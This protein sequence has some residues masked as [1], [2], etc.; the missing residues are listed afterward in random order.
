MGQRGLC[1][2]VGAVFNL[3]T[4]A[5]AAVNHESTDCASLML[6]GTERFNFGR[7]IDTIGKTGTACMTRSKPGSFKGRDDVF[8][9]DPAI[10]NV[11]SLADILS[12]PA[13]VVTRPGVDVRHGQRPGAGD[14]AGFEA[15]FGGGEGR[16]EALGDGV[17]G[18]V[19][20]FF[21]GRVGGW[22]TRLR[23]Y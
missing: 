19:H 7:K 21:S 4:W 12:P 17:G 6:V 22:P 2:T 14:S 20:G 1:Q 16:G 11:N 18:L 5:S 3:L 10:F 23:Q 15:D 8:R 9:L 13:G